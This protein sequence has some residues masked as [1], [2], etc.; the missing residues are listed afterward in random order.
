MI[1]LLQANVDGTHTPLVTEATFN[2]KFV[3]WSV[4][5]V[6]SVCSVWSGL[7]CTVV[8]HAVVCAARVPVPV[9]V[10]GCAH[11]APWYAALFC[12][13]VFRAALCGAVLCYAALE[14]PVLCYA[15]VL[16][17]AMCC[18]MRGVLHPAPSPR[19]PNR[20]AD[21]SHCHRMRV[22]L[23]VQVAL[24]GH[25][26]QYWARLGRTDGR[27]VPLPPYPQG[28]LLG[29]EMSLGRF[30]LPRQHVAQPGHPNHVRRCASFTHILLWVV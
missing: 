16:R 27:D 2:L 24:P 20:P 5:S 21:V 29:G 18:V 13:V 30:Q 19:Q 10:G 26:V 11:T 17:S 9:H 3:T 25:H 4:C 6:C 14:C 7:R 12:A 28:R 23:C 15:V 1:D 22:P 8:R